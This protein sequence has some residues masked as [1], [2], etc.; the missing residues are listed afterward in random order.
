MRALVLLLGLSGGIWIDVPFMEQDKNGC[1]S[2]VIWMIMKYW[3]TDDVPSVIDMQ[4]DLYSPEAGGIYARD[5]ERYFQDHQFRTFAF[6]ADWVDLET[7][8]TE[9]RP[10]IVC[11]EQ[12]GRGVPLHYVVVA[13]VDS[14]RQLVWLNDPA[15]R[16][17][18]AMSRA[19]FE[20]RWMDN[21]TLL[22]LPQQPVDATDSVSQ[23]IVPTGSYGPEMDW[24][25]A[26][27]REQRYADARG[28]VSSILRSNPSD[29]F[30]NDLMATLYFLDSNVDAA[31]K[32]WNR[33]A[34][35]AVRDVRVDPA[36]SLNPVLLE[37][38]LA[39]S[40][41]SVLELREYRETVTRLNATGVF[42]RYELGLEPVGDSRFDVVLRAREKNGPGLSWLRGLPYQTLHPEVF[43]IGRQAINVR[44]I[45]RWDEER[46]RA[47]VSVSSPLSNNPGWR[48]SVEFD[49]RAE[50]WD[51]NSGSVSFRKHELK[52]EL[53][54][55][56]NDRWTWRSGL[57]VTKR[58]SYGL[59][60]VAGIES[61]LIQVP[62]R[63]FAV[64]SSASMETGRTFEANSA[65]F[66]RIESAVRARFAPA[67]DDRY[68]IDAV[69]QAGKALGSPPFDELFAVGM[70]RD[71]RLWLR[72]HHPMRKRSYVVSNWDLQR[73]FYQGTL[74]G[75]S[76]GPFLDSGLASGED[77]SL[78]DAGLQLRLTVLGGIRFDISWGRDLRSGRSLFFTN[79]SH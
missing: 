39:F 49:A 30:A 17:L 9:R 77:R 10:L 45:L 55:I 34:K 8:L 35:P 47:W 25:T 70:D 43:N 3:G 63:R 52:T 11:L 48:Y 57:A 56:V 31:L 79:T 46:R 1:G 65:R 37:R 13:G 68:Q 50:R 23:P 24:A 78:W 15:G 76:V 66:T 59:K 71:Q 41:A 75:V 6:K 7:H 12:N 18:E 4:R 16:K 21:W 60:Y 54:S 38:G 72:G 2:A 28:H 19:E 29:R 58:A 36:L 14:A 20:E 64:D 69:L 33:A 51:E 44:S 53:Q 40:R 74:L 62:E 22:A 32:Y 67:R 26:A 73:K 27:F 5:M 61:R 42:A